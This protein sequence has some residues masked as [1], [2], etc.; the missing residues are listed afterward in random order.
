[1]GAA[2]HR[3]VELRLDEVDR[4]EYLWR[5][6]VAFNRRIAGEE[7]PVRSEDEAW[8]RRRLQYARWLA[9]GSGTLLAAVPEAQP[10]APPV[11]YA[12]LVVRPAGATWEMGEEVGE[13]ESLVVAEEARGRGLGTMLI[14]ACRDH[15]RSRGIGHWGVA[16]VE[17]NVGA[18]RLYERAGFRPYYR[19]FMAEL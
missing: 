13:L 6:M 8:A 9:E 15:L 19:D 2:S 4:V 1:M 7:W 14:A 11:G 18:A 10:Q 5:Q 17:A 3:V 16:V 12:A